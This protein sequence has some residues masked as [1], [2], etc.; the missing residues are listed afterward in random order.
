MLYRLPHAEF[1][2]LTA[3]GAARPLGRA[4]ELA[5]AVDSQFDLQAALTRWVALGLIVDFSILGE[6]ADA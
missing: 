2:C 6:A 1:E 3:L 4:L 5:T